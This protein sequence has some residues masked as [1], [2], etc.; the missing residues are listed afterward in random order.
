MI[1][2]GSFDDVIGTYF[3]DSIKKFSGLADIQTARKFRVIDD[4][5]Y[6][7]FTKNGTNYI[8]CA[9]TADSKVKIV[10]TDGNGV[11]IRSNVISSIPQCN[12]ITY[13]PS[14]GKLWLA[15]PNHGIYTIDYATLDVVDSIEDNDYSFCTV[16]FEDGVLYTLAYYVP[17]SDYRIFKYV[18]GSFEAVLTMPTLDAA[19]FTILYQD[20]CVIDKTA[21][22]TMTSPNMLIVAELESGRCTMYKIGDGS[23]FFAYGE[24]EGIEKV[25]DTVYISSTYGDAN[26]TNIN[27]VFK[28]NI[29]GDLVADSAVFGRYPYPGERSTMYVDSSST[30]T[31]PTG[32]SDAKFSCMTEA[33]MQ[34]KYLDGK[35]FVNIAVAYDGSDPFAVEYITLTGCP[36]DVNG[37][38]NVFGKVVV[39]NCHG[40]FYGFS[41]ADGSQCM[42]LNFQGRIAAYNDGPNL[43]LMAFNGTLNNITPSVDASASTIAEGSAITYGTTSNLIRLEAQT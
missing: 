23:G 31:N 3:D 26:I 4:A 32:Y 25:G 30:A 15:S 40:Q 11:Y 18:N 21:Y 39:E 22:I 34:W 2:D 5:A 33:V 41:V 37:N 24:I 7:S 8:F 36:V 29:L 10:E 28:T 35:Y 43:T 20:M 42:F 19:P 17:M 6:Q 16:S 12:S 1:Q 27:Q 38:G 14:D 9:T 13:N